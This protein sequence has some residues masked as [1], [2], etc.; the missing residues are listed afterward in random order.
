MLPTRAASSFHAAVHDASVARLARA[1][2]KL[3]QTISN[4]GQVDIPAYE[5]LVRAVHLARATASK[6]VV[7]GQ[8]RD[9]AKVTITIPERPWANVAVRDQPPPSAS[10]PSQTPRLDF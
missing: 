7:E 10:A 4:D 2:N 1:A 3:H 6:R 9:T 8:M 5:Q